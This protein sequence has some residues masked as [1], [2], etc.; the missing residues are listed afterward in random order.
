MNDQRVIKI[1]TNLQFRSM[2]PAE[3]T[4][5][6]I[7]RERFMDKF[8]A[9]IGHLCAFKIDKPDEGLLAITRLICD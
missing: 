2:E 7:S 9:F 5:E 3:G 6:L 1:P 8:V 4:P